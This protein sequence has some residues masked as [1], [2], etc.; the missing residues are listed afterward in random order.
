MQF[1][2]FSKASD[3][4]DKT[5]PQLEEHESANN[6]ILGLTFRLIEQPDLYPLPPFLATVENDNGPVLAALMTPPHHII[7]CDFTPDAPSV[8]SMIIDSLRAGH[9]PLPG[10]RAPVGISTAFSQAWSQISGDR[11]ITGQSMGVYELRK[12]LPPA[13][14]AHGKMRLAVD[15]DIELAAQ[16]TYEFTREAL[17]ESYPDGSRRSVEFKIRNKEL[18]FWEDD[19]PVCMA[20]AARPTRHGIMVGSV[21]T[22]PEARQ[23]GYASSLVAELSQLQLDHGYQFV[24][25]F[26]DMANPTSNKIYQNVGYSQISDFQEYHFMPQTRPA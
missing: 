1:Q 14:P 8:C 7:L 3:F 12:V 25:L 9:W 15:E 16:W 22:P 17:H 13:R 19:H 18:Y 6:L 10:V 4:L 20:A 11:I 5:L 24:S 26:T 23:C 2:K 21:Y